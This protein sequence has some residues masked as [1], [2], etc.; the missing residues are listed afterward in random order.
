MLEKKKEKYILVQ[1]DKLLSQDSDR[2]YLKNMK[3]YKSA[4]RPKAYDVHLLYPGKSDSKVAEILAEY[5]T[6]VSNNFSPLEPED[7]PVTYNAGLPYLETHEVANQIRF[8]KKPKSMVKG[9]IFP[10][11]MTKYANYLAIPLQSIYNE[12]TESKIWPLCWKREYVTI[13]P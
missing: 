6:K 1:K 7:I 3:A 4:D 11:L 8:F 9:D 10:C 2:A 5:F 12:I 13:I